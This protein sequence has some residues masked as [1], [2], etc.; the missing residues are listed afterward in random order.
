MCVCYDDCCCNFHRASNSDWT[1]PGA[2][3]CINSPQSG[4]L[5]LEALQLPPSALLDATLAATHEDG[6]KDSAQHQQ[7]QAPQGWAAMPAATG[8][9]PVSYS[10]NGAAQGCVAEQHMNGSNKSIS[11]TASQQQGSAVG[12]Q[13]VAAQSGH[14]TNHT[15]PGTAAEATSL[16]GSTQS[17]AAAPEVAWQPVLP[18]KTL[19]SPAAAAALD[20]SP[21][22]PDSA[23]GAASGAAP[24]TS[25]HER[26]T[27]G[28]FRW[29]SKTP[30][31][32]STNTSKQ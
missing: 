2:S 30:L 32:G 29:L 4:T 9:K 19:G 3:P 20:S 27:S 25:H 21:A 28:L 12:A 15:A 24:V 14:A 7:V 5:Q 1:S 16:P 8:C 11:M 10:S 6:G 18:R 31:D 13:E 26:Q 23:S 22:A 17:I